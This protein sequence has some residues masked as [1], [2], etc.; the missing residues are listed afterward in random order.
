MSKDSS[1]KDITHSHP[2]WLS[3]L[4]TVFT[5]VLLYSVLPSY[6]GLGSVAGSALVSAL[7]EWSALISV[8]WLL[9][10]VKERLHLRHHRQTVSNLKK[11]LSID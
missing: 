9:P 6:V 8:L 2:F 3:A 4:F 7:R 10:H 5:F 1:N 11:A